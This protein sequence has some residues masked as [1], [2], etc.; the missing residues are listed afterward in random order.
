MTVVEDISPQKG[1]ESKH[2]V[3]L[4]DWLCVCVCVWQRGGTQMKGEGQSVRNDFIQYS[5]Y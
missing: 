4:L 2:L 1:N 3:V 5:E